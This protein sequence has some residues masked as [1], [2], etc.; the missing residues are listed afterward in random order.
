MPLEQQAKQDWPY[1]PDRHS[2]NGAVDV[3]VAEP[4]VANEVT[5]VRRQSF[6][7]RAIKGLKRRARGADQTV[8][9]QSNGMAV[10]RD[11]STASLTAGERSWLLRLM[12]ETSLGDFIRDLV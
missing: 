6:I 5:I 12:Q 8:R 2:W 10:Q 7:V 1:A 11:D 3:M 9:S 4:E